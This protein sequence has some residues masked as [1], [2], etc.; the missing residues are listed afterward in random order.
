MRSIAFI[1]SKVSLFQWQWQA[2]A[3]VL[4][5]PAGWL[6]FLTWSLTLSLWHSTTSLWGIRRKGFFSKCFRYAESHFLGSRC[7]FLYLYS[8]LWT[9]PSSER[10]DHLWSLPCGLHGCCPDS[11]RNKVYCRV[12][13]EN[14]F[15]TTNNINEERTKSPNNGL[16]THFIYK[17]IDS[18][19]LKPL[20][21]PPPVG[22]P[23]GHWKGNFPAA[24]LL[25]NDKQSCHV[26]SVMSSCLWKGSPR[27]CNV[28]WYN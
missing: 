5:E 23:F 18:K 19:C 11:L 9:T 14:V 20:W 15:D 10:A 2:V 22:H 28:M 25:S 16:F 24:V 27:T 21:S 13:E 12:E 6:S 8:R 26:V 4:C 3:Y 7:Y 17:K 1:S